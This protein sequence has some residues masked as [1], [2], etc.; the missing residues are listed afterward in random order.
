MVEDASPLRLSGCRI[1]FEF[2]IEF[3]CRFT[4]GVGEPMGS[5]PFQGGGGGH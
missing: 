5:G 3:V 1:E 2:E 4:D